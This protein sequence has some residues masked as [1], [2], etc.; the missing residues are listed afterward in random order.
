M[1]EA[2]QQ[3]KRRAKAEDPAVAKARNRAEAPEI[4]TTTADRPRG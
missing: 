2:E 4:P 3:G 1:I